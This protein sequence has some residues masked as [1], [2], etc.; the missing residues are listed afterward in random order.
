MRLLQSEIENQKRSKL[1]KAQLCTEIA[2]Q[3][4]KPNNKLTFQ[5][6]LGKAFGSWLH[7]A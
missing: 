3:V 6:N 5:V 7:C 2:K 4:K 1:P